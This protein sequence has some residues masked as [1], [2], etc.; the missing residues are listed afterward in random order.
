MMKR[1]PTAM[2]PE[3][4]GKGSGLINTPESFVFEGYRAKGGQKPALGKGKKGGKPKTRSSKR[5]AAFKA[6]GGKKKRG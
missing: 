1:A 6:S 2:G 4:S 5:G 3:G